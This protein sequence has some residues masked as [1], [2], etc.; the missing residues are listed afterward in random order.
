M[1]KI[2]VNPSKNSPYPSK[3]VCLHEMLHKENYL[4]LEK[5]IPMYKF[6]NQYSKRNGLPAWLYHNP[7]EEKLQAEKCYTVEWDYYS[8]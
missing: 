7:P 3:H 5:V 2:G 1:C 4:S 6:A 8:L